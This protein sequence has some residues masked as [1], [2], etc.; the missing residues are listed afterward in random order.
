[1]AIETDKLTALLVKTLASP[2]AAARKHFDGGGL[3]LDVRANSSRYWRMAYRFAGR[4]RL[5]SF[6]VYPEVTLAEARRRRDQA[7]ALL[8]VGTDPAAAK[9]EQNSS[10][11]RIAEAAFPRVAAAWLESKRK[12]W[13]EE[14]YRK[15]E[16][17]LNTY[18]IPSLR[19]HS[20]ATLKSKDAILALQ[21][22]PPAVA[23]KARQYLGG[24]AVFAIQ[25]ELRDDGR[26]LIMKGAI[27]RQDR[28]HIPAATTPASLRAVAMA[29]DKYEVPVTRYA[30]TLTMLTA[31]R[32]G[33]VAAAEWSEFDL[34]AAEWSIPG[35]KMK[36]RKAHIVPLPTQAVELLQTMHVWTSG[37]R[38]VFPPL[39]RQKTEHL[40]RDTLSKALRDMG[41][42]GKHATH[43]FRTAFRTIARERLG[44]DVDVLE[45]QLA[46]AKKGEVQ[47]AYD[48]TEFT[49]D[50]RR[51]MQVWADYLDSLRVNNIIDSL[52]ARRADMQSQRVAT[53]NLRR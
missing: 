26:L 10:A 8:R 16:Y 30:L 44:I 51:L 48:R 6:G 1:M 24:I 5:L 45:A 31:Q 36:M 41:F 38:Y 28:G 4:E 7:R 13:A 19:R 29:I 32:P 49:D 14:T 12:G 25:D 43:G 27:S 17:V 11:R 53:S 42:K 35:S 23:R 37:K 50:R 34:D 52:S 21:N 18:L 20:I 15:A 39:A 40:H 2:G 9:A 46:H 47:Q 22:I 33:L 3:Y